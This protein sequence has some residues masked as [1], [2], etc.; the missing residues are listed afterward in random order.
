MTRKES[1]VNEIHPAIFCGP[2]SR[3]QNRVDS[4]HTSPS[5]IKVNVKGKLSRHTNFSTILNQHFTCTWH[6]VSTRN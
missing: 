5:H 6:A 1:S 3:T 4:H 2:T